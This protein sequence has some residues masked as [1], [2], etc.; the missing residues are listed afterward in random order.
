MGVSPRVERGPLRA[1]RACKARYAPFDGTGA[2]LEGGRWNSPGAP[3]VYAAL[4]YAGALLEILVHAGTD[5]LPGPHH[6]VTI[7]VPGDVA[8]E[9]LLPEDVAGWDAPNE[10][11]PRRAGDAWRAAGRSAILLVPSVVAAPHDWNVVIDPRH[12]DAARLLVSAPTPVHWDP[13]LFASV[14]RSA[15]SG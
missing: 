3:V 8:V 4:S 11:A 6:A 7:D 15:P 2:A 13:R 10:R 14:R 1:V 12:P 9:R 5:D